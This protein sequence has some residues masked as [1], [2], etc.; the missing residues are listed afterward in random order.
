M[1]QGTEQW[2]A[3]RLGKVTASRVADVMAKTKTGPAASRKNYMMELLCQR[4]TGR[5]EDGFT[6][7]A[8]QR[9]TE[10][11]PI[12]R[13]LYEAESGI[14]VEQEGFIDHPEIEWFGA[15]PDGLV[16]DAGLIEIK[17]PNTATHIDFM[18]SR[19]PDSRYQWQMLAQMACTGRE[20]CDFVSYDDRLPEH[21]QLICE[22]F[23]RDDERIS[24]M[25]AEI[26]AFLAELGK[27]T[28]ELERTAA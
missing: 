19:K 20:W 4:L 7:A 6:S 9:G 14:L 13:V 1:E 27:L 10:L 5:S 2:F 11:E 17:C 25:E 8:M 23:H 28:Q 12:A 3:A 21:L 16:G 15:S 18:R 24:Q 22:R 26:R